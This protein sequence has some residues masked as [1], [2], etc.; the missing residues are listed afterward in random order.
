MDD[1]QRQPVDPLPLD[2]RTGLPQKR[3]PVGMRR[4][5]VIALAM[6]L[7]AITIAGVLGVMRA[8]QLGG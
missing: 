7:A 6:L 3:E 1:Q 4:N 5:T 8:W 2:P